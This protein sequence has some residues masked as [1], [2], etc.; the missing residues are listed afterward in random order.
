VPA[1]PSAALVGRAFQPSRTRLEM[2]R[3]AYVSGPSAGH[4]ARCPDTGGRKTSIFSP[5]A[6]TALLARRSE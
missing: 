2:A 1:G 5:T 3:Q 6:L 4:R